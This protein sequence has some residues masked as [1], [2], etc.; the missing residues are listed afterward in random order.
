MSEVIHTMS[1]EF[2]NK[3][4]DVSEIIKYMDILNVNPNMQSC[5]LIQNG[6]IFHHI[7]YNTIKN[8]NYYN[9][10]YDILN[11]KYIDENI[12]NNLNLT[13]NDYSKYDL[14]EKFAKLKELKDSKKKQRRLSKSIFFAEKDALFVEL[15]KMIE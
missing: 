13:P 14:H 11:K 6:N 4:K 10:L 5:F 1:S 3:N 15:Q 9:N 12:F 7:A 2:I 8:H